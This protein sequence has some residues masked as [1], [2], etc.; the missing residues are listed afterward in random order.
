MASTPPVFATAAEIRGPSAAGPGAARAIGSRRGHRCRPEQASVPAPVFAN[1]RGNPG[2]GPGQNSDFPE[3]ATERFS[4][5]RVT[6]PSPGTK[7]R[8]RVRRRTPFPRQPDPAGFAAAPARGRLTSP[9]SIASEHRFSGA[10]S[11]QT[12][13]RMT[14]CRGVSGSPRRG[15]RF[16]PPCLAG[17]SLNPGRSPPGAGIGSGARRPPGVAKGNALSTANPCRKTRAADVASRTAR[18]LAPLFA[19]SEG[20]GL[21][22]APGAVNRYTG[23][24]PTRIPPATASFCA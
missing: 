2:L 23:S 20:S 9:V 16:G 13:V 7:P 24:A 10:G 5:G 22:L 18:P 4:G 6:V 15:P 17:P 21:R 3:T 8:S 1:R 19:G 11:R 14:Q 12:S